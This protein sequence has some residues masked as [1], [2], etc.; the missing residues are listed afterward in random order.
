MPGGESL[1]D[2][3]RYL[4]EVNEH[5][6]STVQALL[7]VAL[8]VLYE[9]EARYPQAQFGL[10]RRMH[11]SDKNRERPSAIVTPDLVAQRGS[12]G[13]V[14]E[15]KRSLP[16][17][18]SL[19]E[20]HIRQLRK[21]DDE[22]TGWWTPTETLPGPSDA[23]ALIHYSRAR[24][25]VDE[26]ER[27]SASND[28][29][30]NRPPLVIEFH[31]SE[32][33]ATYI[34]LRKERGTVSEPDLDRRL[35]EGMPV[36]LEAVIA[37]FPVVT[38]YD[39]PPEPEYI[40]QILWL[41]IL[42]ERSRRYEYDARLGCI[43]VPVSSRAITEELQLAFGHRALQ[44]DERSV[45]FPRHGWVREA[46]DALVSLH[47]AE[48][49]PESTDDDYRVFYRDIQGD[50]L[51]RFARRRVTQAP[52]KSPLPGQTELGLDAQE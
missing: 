26:L 20:R 36:P 30:F 48:R 2:V 50:I 6:E 43:P 12:M 28:H 17:D 24:A 23:A 3:V 14:V 32:E 25:F 44:C 37:Q 21:Y 29:L 19:W 42:P 41:D 13:L 8:A 45:E 39:S 11:T 5:Y 18:R 31:R 35:H 27:L 10:G 46:L 33:V 22:L 51:E 15:A 34:S 49:L 40:L 38:F 52:V 16:A 9:G 4:R 7:A 1:A 47:L